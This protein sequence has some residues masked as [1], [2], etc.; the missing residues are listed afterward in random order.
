MRSNTTLGDEYVWASCTCSCDM[1]N[2]LFLSI[3]LISSLLRTHRFKQ[4]PH[5]W[6]TGVRP[7]LAVSV[8]YQRC[9]PSRSCLSVNRKYLSLLITGQPS[10]GDQG[11][12]RR[13]LYF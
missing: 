13:E 4:T 11:L 1:A 8:E 2:P 10:V 12:A 3:Y 6:R 7:L 5:L 9:E